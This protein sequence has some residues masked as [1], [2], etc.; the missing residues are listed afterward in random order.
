MKSDRHSYA[1]GHSGIMSSNFQ[2]I[3]SHPVPFMD[4]FCRD[5]PDRR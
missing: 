1:P 3:I 2:T 4:T 5:L